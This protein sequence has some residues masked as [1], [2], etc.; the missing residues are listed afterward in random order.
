MT[1]HELARLLLDGPDVEVV[2]Q[3]FGHRYHSED[4][5]Q[6]HGAM[7]VGVHELG[8]RRRRSLVLSDGP[9][10]PQHGDRS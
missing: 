9:Y 8:Y 4:D 10:R 5:R 2:L 7:S 1:A 3:V 6:S